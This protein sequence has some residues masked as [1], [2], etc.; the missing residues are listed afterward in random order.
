MTEKVIYSKRDDAGVNIA[1]ILEKKYNYDPL[2]LEDSVLFLDEDSDPFHESDLTIVASRHASKSGKPTLSCHAPGNFASA[3]YGGFPRELSFVNACS[4]DVALN[5]L[6]KKE[7]ELDLGFDVC[8][9]CTHHGPTS[10]PYPVLFVEVGSTK[11][12]WNNMDAC[13]AAACAIHNTIDKYK[14]QDKPAAIG[15]GGGHYS[16]KFSKITDYA[17]GHIC[18]KYNLGNIDEKMVDQMIQKT[19]PSPDYALVEEKGVGK[20]KERDRI[21]DVLSVFDLRVIRV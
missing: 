9:E 20:A 13:E 18:P 7:D 3:D 19:V 15:F 16:R 10:L 14:E 6:F 2:G 4:M 21:L 17:F 5:A 11:D 12:Q 8:F 1:G